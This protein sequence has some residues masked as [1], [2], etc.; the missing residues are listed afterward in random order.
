[1][2]PP[3][4]VEGGVVIEVPVPNDAAVMPDDK[5]PMPMPGDET[6]V[7]D[8]VTVVPGPNDVSGIEP[9]KPLH[10]GRPPIDVG[11]EGDA[12]A[13]NGLTPGAES[14]V[15]P[16]GTRVGG[17]G[18]SEPMPSGD[19]AP[20]GGSPGDI[21]AKTGPQAN[22]AAAAL[23]IAKRIIGFNRILDRIHCPRPESSRVGRQ[24]VSHVGGVGPRVGPVNAY[25]GMT[26]SL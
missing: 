17:G 5:P 6:P 2:P 22:S 26:R 1:M 23:A 7:P 8:A 24:P 13:G 19:V 16:S 18:R 21:W 25:L 14:S 10:P 9:P 4:N 15:A 11:A 20:S 12:P 3:S